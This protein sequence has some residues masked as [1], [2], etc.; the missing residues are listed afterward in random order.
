MKIIY[1]VINVSI[2]EIVLDKIKAMEITDYQIIEQVLSHESLVN[3][4][5]NTSVW[6]GYS[7]AIIIQSDQDE[8]IQSLF[9]EIKNFNSESVNDEE[10]IRAFSWNTEMYI[11]D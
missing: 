1:L 7:S 9:A 2:L 4:R 11:I 6:P 5:M 3:P 10:R 8:K